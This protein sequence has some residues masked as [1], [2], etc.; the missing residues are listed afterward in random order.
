MKRLKNHHEE[1]PYNKAVKAA[2]FLILKEAKGMLAT[3]EHEELRYTL[4]REEKLITPIQ[5]VIYEMVNPLLYLRLECGSDDLY[6][7]H[8]GFEQIN[9]DAQLSN[10]TASFTR[11]IYRLTS[12]EITDVNIEACVSNSWCITN[13]SDLFEYVNDQMKHH[14]FHLIKYKSATSKRKAMKAVA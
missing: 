10:R 3:I 9:N 13:C 12:K 1:Y 6:I 14:Q 5:R 11:L 4:V 7:I 2:F 8:Y